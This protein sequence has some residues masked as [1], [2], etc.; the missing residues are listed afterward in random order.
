M[1]KPVYACSVQSM[2]RNLDVGVQDRTG[3]MTGNPVCSVVSRSCPLYQSRLFISVYPTLYK[4]IDAE[5]NAPVCCIDLTVR[6]NHFYSL[7]N[8]KTIFV[9]IYKYNITIRFSEGP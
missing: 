2:T 3:T 4:R 1:P 9:L 7:H 5:I 8:M 6:K